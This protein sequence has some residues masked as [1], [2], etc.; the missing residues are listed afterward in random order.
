MEV[1]TLSFDEIDCVV[2]YMKHGMHDRVAGRL[3]RSWVTHLHWWGDQNFI[4]EKL[5]KNGFVTRVMH[6]M[7]DQDEPVGSSPPTWNF[8]RS[9]IGSKPDTPFD[10]QEFRKLYAGV[11]THDVEEGRTDEEIL[12]GDADGSYRAIR[13]VV[14]VPTV[15]VQEARRNPG[16]DDL[17]QR[18]VKDYPRLFS[19]LANKIHPDRGRF[20]PHRLN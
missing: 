10:I 11:L 20:D 2:H 17:R 4:T 12:D 18:F 5:T 8:P 1:K 13:S 3:A 9:G 6:R 15:A 14:T 19:V 7:A 16:V